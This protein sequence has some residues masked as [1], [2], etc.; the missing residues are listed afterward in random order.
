MCMQL[1]RYTYINTHTHKRTHFNAS[2]HILNTQS[3]EGEEDGVDYSQVDV[4]Y[5]ELLDR[6]DA[7][8]QSALAASTTA[9][10]GKHSSKVRVFA[11]VCA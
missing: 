7:L 1:H 10:S 3:G 6:L 4:M 9:S 8:D 5:D 2:T 11:C